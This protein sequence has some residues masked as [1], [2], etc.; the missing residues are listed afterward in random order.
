MISRESNLK[1]GEFDSM[2]QQYE[3]QLAEKN[4]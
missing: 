3:R 2:R 1:N 4:T